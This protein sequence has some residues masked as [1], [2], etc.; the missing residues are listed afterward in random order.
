MHSFNESIRWVQAIIFQG[1]RVLSARSDFSKRG[2]ISS[3]DR[4]EEQFFLNACEKAVRWIRALSKEGR[5]EDICGYFPAEEIR[6]FRRSMDSTGIRN[7]REHEEE[8]LRTG[9]K[10]LK[11]HIVDASSPEG[12]PTIMVEPGITVLR[13]GNVII[14]GKVSVQ[15]TIEVAERLNHALVIAQHDYARFKYPVIKDANPDEYPHIFAAFQLS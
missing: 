11:D 5:D 15:K 14:G 1:S 4:V 2:A 13:D 6:E 7:L 8:Y 9:G 10:S 3:R 12:G